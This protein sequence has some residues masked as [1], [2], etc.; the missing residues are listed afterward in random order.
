VNKNVVT[1]FLGVLAV[2]LLLTVTKPAFADDID[3]LLS[4]CDIAPKPEPY[5]MV[6]DYELSPET[7]MTGDIAVLTVTLKNMQEKPIEKELDIKRD[8]KGTSGY[9]V[10]V[11]TETRYTMDAYIKEAYIVE[12]D[13]KVY[14]KYISAGVIG[15]DNKVDL[16]Y[17]LKAPAAEGIYM[18]KFV[19]NI[20]DM[21]GK[22]SKG[23]RYFIPIQVS[24]A[25]NLLSMGI[26]ENEV[27]LEVINE[28]LSDVD[29]VYVVA[30]NVTGAEIQ[31]EKVYLGDINA[32]DSA[33]VVFKVTNATEA[34]TATFNAVFMHGTNKHESDPV[35]L[36]LPCSKQQ[37][38]EQ[39]ES[40][41]AFEHQPAS[42]VPASSSPSSSSS[43]KLPGYGAVLAFSGL[44]AAGLLCL[45]RRER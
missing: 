36:K 17:K 22:R 18:L 29:C 32:G 40:N 19:A 14:N 39:S 15:P 11:D 2:M 7:L 26:S 34:C 41:N 24:G 10:D 21:N 37:L 20:E 16:K 5:A 42:H 1:L 13:F 4:K 9:I 44:L 25:V 31:P 33:V 23:I 6:Y 43:S 30:S 38:E 35:Y 3:D 28:C 45:V 12:K 27:N 8:K